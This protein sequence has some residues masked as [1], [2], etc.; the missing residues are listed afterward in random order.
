MAVH[1]RI[2]ELGAYSAGHDADDVMWAFRTLDAFY[3][4]VAAAGEAVLIQWW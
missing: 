4:G 3:R 1:V 2:G